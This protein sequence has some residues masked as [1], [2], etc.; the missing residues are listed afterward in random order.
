MSGRCYP[1]D[2]NSTS[3]K[4]M[5]LVLFLF[6]LGRVVQVDSFKTRVES[7]SGCNT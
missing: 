5:Q 2:F 3:K 1:R 4:P 6:A 7:A